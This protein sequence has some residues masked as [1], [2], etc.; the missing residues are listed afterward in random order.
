MITNEHLQFYKENGYLIIRNF[1]SS[2]KLDMLSSKYNE[3]RI[4]LANS[5]GI[6]IAD[7]QNEISQVRDIWKYDDTFKNLILNEEIAKVAPLFFESNSC[8]LLH[9][10]IINK[11]LGNNGTVPWHQDYT[12]W[13][14]DNPN[15]L[16]F[17]LPFSDL[18]EKAGVLEV[19]VKS[20]LWGEEAPVDFINDQKDFSNYDVKSLT[21]KKGDL[22]ILNALSWH[23]TSEN[24]SVKER[25]AYISLWIPTNSK[26]A[27]KH[28]SWHPVNDNV[29]VNDN[30]ELN[31]DWFPVIGEKEISTQNYEYVD[32]SATENMSKIT[33][34]NAS[35]IAKKFLQTHLKVE[36][37][38]IW[39]HLYNEESRSEAVQILLDKFT[40]SETLKNELDK[41]ILS[42]SVNGL[43]YQNH[44]A[45]NVYNKSYVKFKEIFNDD[46]M[47]AEQ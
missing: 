15:G 21:V 47:K 36:N 23:R 1:L 43:A 16:S 24:T 19:V 4:R 5:A 10:H 39:R 9:D 20:H 45:R 31:N 28:A 35:K 44:R 29:T 22:V 12:Y 6:K 25:Q 2:T 13:P 8:R 40:L 42:M 34:Y 30:E 38:I 18:D 41:I 37:D 3:L 11:P 46:L 27:P 26:Y 33:M 14:V 32:N 7:Y 17:W